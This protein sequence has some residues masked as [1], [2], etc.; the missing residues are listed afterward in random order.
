M[1]NQET[2]VLSQECGEDHQSPFFGLMLPWQ[3]LN[4]LILPFARGGEEGFL[5][6][7]LL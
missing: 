4:Y 1:N 5:Q 2:E 7:V 3:G 6:N